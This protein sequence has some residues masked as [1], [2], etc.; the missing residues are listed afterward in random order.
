MALLQYLKYKNGL[1]NPK[2]LSSL[3]IPS[4]VIENTN[5]EVKK[6]LWALETKKKPGT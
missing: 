3:E 4:P 1:P 5:T 6:V 2:G